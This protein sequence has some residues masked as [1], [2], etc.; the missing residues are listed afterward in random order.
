MPTMASA[1]PLVERKVP[2]TGE[3]LPV[4]GL[5]TWQTFDVGGSAAER[6]P[7]SD[8][9]QRFAARGARVVDSSPMYGRAEAVVGDLAASRGIR[10]SLFLATKVWTSGREA[11]V[12]QMERSL[13]LLDAEH[14]DLMQVH[15]LVD[16]ATHLETI[17]A[18][19]ADG[20]V[21]YAG[22]THYVASAFP[23]L[24]RLLLTRRLDFVQ[25]NYSIGDR[26][27]EQRLLSVAADRGV[28]VLVNRPFGSGGLFD[29]VRGKELPEWAGEAGVASWAQ[30]F[31][32]Y[33]L[34]HPAVTCA[35]PATSSAKHLDD[36][37]DAGSA[38]L[39]DEATRRRMAAY[40]DAL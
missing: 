29:R 20:R 6:A 18:W 13:E 8:V 4:V 26:E 36:N 7:L 32:K 21:R 10:P 22:V 19:K 35:I 33:V 27:A 23:D 38:P 37:L 24:E 1:R 9:L 17:A 16:V 39:P 25:F 28:A 11:G 12:M 15:N 5:G 31:L 2:S 30:F 3:R 40:F 14:I 34:G